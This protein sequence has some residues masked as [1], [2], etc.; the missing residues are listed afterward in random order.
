MIAPSDFRIVNCMNKIAI[1]EPVGGHGGMNYYDFGLAGGLAKAGCQVRVYTCEKTIVPQGLPFECVLAF[2]GVYGSGNKFFRAAKFFVGLAR[3]VFD[4]KAWGANVAHFHFFH[5]GALESAMVGFAKL[6][7]LKVVVTVHDVE[8]F[9]GDH[10]G[11]RSLSVL[12]KAD[13]L[14]AHNQVSKSELVDK[15]GVDASIVSV[16]P[17]GNY[18]E[19]STDDIDKCSARE[20]LGFPTDVPILLF[21]GQIKEVK[22]L[23]Y[24]IEAASLLKK[25]GVDFRLVVAGK[26]WKASF[27]KYQAMIDGLDISDKVIKDIRYIPDEEALCFYAAADLVVLPYKKIYQSGV[28]L[29]AMSLGVPVVASDLPGMCEVVK[30]RHNGFIFKSEDSESL[31][32]VLES[33]VGRIDVLKTTRDAALEDMRENYSWGVIG[34]RTLSVYQMIGSK[35]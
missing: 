27:E 8:S 20:R 17:H 30:D 9:A 33:V 29:M 13:A 11:R 10:S 23:E 21:F 6:A 15:I 34:E 16:V 7:G 22:G 31:A 28:L 24:A 14:I 1:I 25:R 26:V 18:I 12:S 2:V 32:S 4:A 3:S 19:F 35:A 5:C